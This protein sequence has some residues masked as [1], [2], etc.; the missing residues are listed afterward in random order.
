MLSQIILDAAAATSCAATDQALPA[1]LQA[2]ATPRGASA[3]APGR[4]A[5]LMLGPQPV[6][7][8]RPASRAFSGH[9]PLRIAQAGRYGIAFSHAAWIDVTRGKEPALVSVA[10]GHGPACSSIRKIVDFDLRPG[11]YRV[12]FTNSPAANVR[13]MVVRR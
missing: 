7:G 3:L 13:A 10:H 11:N 4:A 9:F 2:W 5:S 6:A 1:P 8:E 12:Q